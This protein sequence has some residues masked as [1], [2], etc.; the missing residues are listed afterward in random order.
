LP[1]QPLAR[2]LTLLA[3]LALLL[4]GAEARAEHDLLPDAII[5]ESWLDSNEADWSTTPGCVH[6]RLSNGTA[7]AGEGPLHV[8]GVLPGNPDGTQDV[9]QRIFRD[10]GTWWDRLAGVFVFHR[11]HN[12]IHFEGWAAYRLRERL[13][14]GDVGPILVEGEKTSFCLQDTLPYDV[15]LPGAP[16]APVYIECASTVQGISAGWQDIYTRSLPGQSVK[17][18]GTTGGEFWLEAE[19]DPD[20]SVLEVDETNNVARVL[21]EVPPPP[22]C[23]DGLDNDGDGLVDHPLDPGC[24]GLGKPTENPDCDDDLDNDGDGLVDYP[25]DPGC[26]RA[27]QP[28]E[29]PACNNHVDDD[30]DGRVDHPD[31]PTCTSA[32]VATESD[33]SCGLGFE[34][35]LVLPLWQWR[36]RRVRRA[37]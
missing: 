13:P 16:P 31:D 26:A 1:T 30:G 19:V 9:Y 10:D 12:H 17:L 23:N 2:R 21:V 20:D 14:N 4:A 32:S 24:G 7:N 3:V 25:L 5:V 22:A 18:C 37:A 35:A 6:V 8:Y 11:T 28:T 36:R 33:R 15:S 27:S 34:L 29:A